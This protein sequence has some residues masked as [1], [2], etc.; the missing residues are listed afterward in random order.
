MARIVVDGTPYEVPDGRNLLHACLSLGLDL[1]YFCWH[2]ALGSVGACRQ[3]AV[4]QLEDEDDAR[5]KLVMACMTAAD[6]GARI[7]IEDEEAAAFRASVIEWLMVNHPHDCPVCD[8]GGECH[9]Q[10][11]TVMT[12]HDYRRFRFDKRTHRNQDLGPFIHHEMNRCIACYR[13]V[14]FYRD[15]AGGRD[16]DVLGAHD[17]VYFGRHADGALESEFAGNLVEVCPTGVF[18]DKTLKRHYTRKWDLQTAPSICVHCGLGCNTIAGERYGTL[19]RILNRYHHEVNGYFLCDRGRFGYEFVNSPERVRRPLAR[20]G[21][22]PA[23]LEPVGLLGARERLRAIFVAAGGKG[24]RPRIWGIGSPRA[25]LEA[26]FALRRLVGPERCSTG[27]GRAENELVAA[28]LAIFRDGPVRTPSLEEVRRSDAVLVL[29]EDPSDTAPILA[30]ALRRTV[31][32]QPLAVARKLGIPEWHDRAVREAVQDR[33][34]PLYVATPAATR[35]DALAR[36][37]LRAAPDGI[38]RLGFAVAR[39]LDSESPAAPGAS[40][41]LLQLASRIARH[42]REAE[43]PLVVSGTGAGSRAVIEAAAAVARALLATRST[44]GATKGELGGPAPAG[45]VLTVPEANSLGVALLCAE[46]GAGGGGFDGIGGR[47][48]EAVFEAVGRGEA[49]AVVVL[50]ND[51]FRRAP[52]AEVAAFLAAV[53]AL[54]VLDHLAHRTAEAADLVLPAATFAEGDGTWISNEGRAQR[55][56]QVFVPEEGE[57]LAGWRWVAEI[58]RCRAPERGGGAAEGFDWPGLDDV[59]AALAAELPAFAALPGAFPDAGYRQA[60]LPVPREPARAS[61]RTSIHAALTVHEPAPPADPDAPLAFSMEGTRRQPPAALVPAYWAPRWNSVQA[62]NKLQEEVA[63]PLRGGDAGVR[64][65]EP[66]EPRKARGGD[67]G[68][69]PEPSPEP[70]GDPGDGLLTVVALH[71]VFGGEELSARAPAVAERAPAP[72]LALRPDDARRLAGE[73]AD[74]DEVVLELTDG[75]LRLPVRFRSDLP[76]GVAGLPVGLAGVGYHALPATGR[77]RP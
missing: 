69:P 75:A 20:R 7:S 37:T 47:P 40:E 17:H 49:D 68:R 61:G 1:P 6:D 5:G 58:A 74:G 12:G 29:G 41:E 54:V 4:K 18:T 62:L 28:A 11:M 73:V 16:L 3:C 56:Y 67:R 52:E 53:P 36:E 44:K 27:M 70:E 60:G 45:L 39:A 71:H 13:C 32:R 66:G 21:P 48:V 50:E 8:E 63:G 19:R 10:D 2:P 77:L 64:L 30:L 25:S 26:N 15:H 42:L 23:G 22:G 34:G 55:G 24:R 14:R 57:V 76:P 51:L 35:L 72:Y 9:L 31:E 65:V 38:A 33:K 43:R 46:D 59:V